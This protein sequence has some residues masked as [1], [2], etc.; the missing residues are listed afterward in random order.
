M[1]PTPTLHPI[2]AVYV[3]SEPL[4]N[5]WPQLTPIVQEVFSLARRLGI[6]V[7]VP[8][9]VISE[10]EAQFC[11]KLRTQAEAARLAH[12]RLERIACIDAPYQSIDEDAALSAFR[13]RVSQVISNYE[14][15]SVPL[16]RRTTSELFEHALHLRPPFKPIGP[17]EEH[18]DAGFK[19][20]VIAF[21]VIDHADGQYRPG[22]AV[23]MTGDGGY[24]GFEKFARSPDQ[25][26]SADVALVRD[27]LRT[28]RAL[29][30]LA[31]VET[32]VTGTFSGSAYFVKFELLGD[33]VQLVNEGGEGVVMPSV[34]TPCEA[35]QLIEV[36][37]WASGS[38]IGSGP[39]EVKGHRWPRAHYSGEVRINA[40][41]IVA[42]SQSQ[43]VE[44]PVSCCGLLAGHDDNPNGNAATLFRLGVRGTGTARLSL[45]VDPQDGFL[46]VNCEN[47]TYHLTA[48]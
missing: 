27:S 31:E 6:P 48:Q 37:S 39:A 11:R 22:K 7:Y 44:V 19:D 18:K 35:G 14:L 47:V 12:S 28:G 29:E 3:D 38:F 46:L 43:I 40:P 21:S 1:Q 13:S 36:E 26:T 45:R 32:L 10:L 15:Y 24:A 41:A 8:D 23:L 5:R 42:P 33:G 4:S 30:A 25:L 16:T 20:A 17:K 2:S 34:S 9:A